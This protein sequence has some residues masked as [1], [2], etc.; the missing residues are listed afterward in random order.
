M[1]REIINRLFEYTYFKKV[2]DT[3]LAPLL[4]ADRAYISHIKNGKKKLTFEKFE[5]LYNHFTDL[6]L[7]WLFRGAALNKKNDQYIS[8]NYNLQAGNSIVGDPAAL[9]LENRY[10]KEL[11]KGKDSQIELL[12]K[13]LK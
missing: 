3:D 13:M 7:N 1:K 11:M 10:L 4:N 5:H 6:D 9:E 8:R 12:K 2:K